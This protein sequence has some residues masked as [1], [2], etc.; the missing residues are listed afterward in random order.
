MTCIHPKALELY[1]QLKEATSNIFFWMKPVRFKFSFNYKN[2][3]KMGEKS[4]FISHSCFE[5]YTCTCTKSY[6]DKFTL[7][8]TIY[9]LKGKKARD[10]RC[11]FGFSRL[12]C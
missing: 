9:K 3:D 4:V 10:P 5:M 2:C 7:P 12:K 11:K 8:I 1:R 6:Y